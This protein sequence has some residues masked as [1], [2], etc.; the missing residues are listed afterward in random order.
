MFPEYGLSKA[1]KIYFPRSTQR[2]QRFEYTKVLRGKK[3]K[4]SRK[5]F[6]VYVSGLKRNLS[7]FP[8]EGA[9]GRKVILCDVDER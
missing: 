1:R 6:L 2:A 3:F 5:E 8:T 7:E 4:D 9:K